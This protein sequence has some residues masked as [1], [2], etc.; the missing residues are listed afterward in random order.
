MPRASGAKERQI[1]DTPHV[2]S[3]RWRFD[4]K[5]GPRGTMTSVPQALGPRVTVVAR[6]SRGA[7]AYLG[8][9][10]LVIERGSGEIDV[11]RIVFDIEHLHSIVTH[12]SPVLLNSVVN[13]WEK[14]G[15]KSLLRLAWIPPTTSLRDVQQFFC[16]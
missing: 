3:R 7:Q 2:I 14:I 11:G 12:F 4:L 15:R 10:L 6:R 16:K 9:D 13:S 1:G 8:S 5:V